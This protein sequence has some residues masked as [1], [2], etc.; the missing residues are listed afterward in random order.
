MDS[1]KRINVICGQTSVGSCTVIAHNSNVNPYTFNIGSG[2]Q[3]SGV[4][5]N[6][7]PG[8]YT[9][10]VID[11]TGCTIKDSFSIKVLIP[12]EANFTFSPTNI[13]VGTSIQFNNTSTGVN[14]LTWFYNDTLFSSAGSTSLTIN[15]AGTYSVTLIGWY[16]LPQC[17]DTMTKILVAKECPPDSFVVVAPNIF[18]PNGDN[19]NEAWQPLIY[20]SGFTI[21]N[22][23]VN[24][25]DRWGLKVFQ[26]TAGN[27][28]AWDGRS[29]SGIECSQGTYYYIVNYKII[30]STGKEKQETIKG[31]LQLMR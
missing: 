29:T 9:V 23:E 30:G 21:E 18:T 4:F 5:T 28:Q 13:C 2:A 1:I 14:N 20:E 27:K 12:Y 31:F 7:N 11:N 17:S 10:T 24:I 22:F 15:H 19:I 6:L 26:T 25:F 3:N 16:N 8:N